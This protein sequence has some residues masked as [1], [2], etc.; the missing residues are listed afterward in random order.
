MDI[1]NVNL[2]KIES[3]PIIGEPWH[4]LFYLDILLDKTEDYHNMIH[5]IRPLI[6][7]LDILGE[8]NCGKHS[9]NNLKIQ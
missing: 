6:D 7:K 8:Y 4:Y 5:A 1:Y 9:L 2:S 3:V